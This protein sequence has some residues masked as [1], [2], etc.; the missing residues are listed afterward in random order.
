MSK[1]G[2]QSCNVFVINKKD[3]HLPALTTWVLFMKL[4]IHLQI[5]IF[6]FLTYVFPFSKWVRRG[7]RLWQTEEDPGSQG[8]VDVT[9]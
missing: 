6:H 8:G 1:Q 7:R 9:L 4:E 2:A 3:V 5:D